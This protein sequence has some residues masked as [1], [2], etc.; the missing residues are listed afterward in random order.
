MQTNHIFKQKH[1]FLCLQNNTINLDY[2]NTKLYED[3]PDRSLFLIN[4]N[5]ST[6]NYQ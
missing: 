6:Y 1:Y 4:V 2:T 5:N 3:I